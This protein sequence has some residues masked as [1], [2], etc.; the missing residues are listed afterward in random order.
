MREGALSFEASRSY[1]Q[2][3]KQLHSRVLCPGLC[4]IHKLFLTKLSILPISAFT[5]TLGPL[6]HLL[7]QRSEEPVTLLS[8]GL[9]HPSRVHRWVVRSLS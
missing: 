6:P 2:T 5:P 7:V 4:I 9:T 3:T 1:Y 8:P